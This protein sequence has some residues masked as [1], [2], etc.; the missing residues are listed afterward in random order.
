MRFPM[1]LASVRKLTV[2]AMLLACGAYAAAQAARAS[3]MVPTGKGF[4]AQNDSAPPIVEGNETNRSNGQSGNANGHR[5]GGGNNGI[6]F[7]GGPVM[8]GAPGTAV[9]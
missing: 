4:A 9:N 1:N 8:T 6:S 3:N 2:L 7:H 5:G